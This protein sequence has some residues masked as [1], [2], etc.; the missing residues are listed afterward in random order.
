MNTQEEW[1]RTQDMRNTRFSTPASPTPGPS[2]PRLASEFTNE[3]TDNAVL[4]IISR[5][6]VWQFIQDMCN[7]KYKDQLEGNI[8]THAGCG[9]AA[10]DMDCAWNNGNE[11]KSPF[12][13][14]GV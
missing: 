6:Q 13:F 10:S 11:A 4:G 8:G 3:K 7:T 2:T 1:Q 5:H 12:V 14:F 9:V